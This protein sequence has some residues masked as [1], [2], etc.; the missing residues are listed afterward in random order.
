M[1]K[2]YRPAGRVAAS[3]LILVLALIAVPSLP[4]TDRPATAGMT[5]SSLPAAA[6]DTSVT[7]VGAASSVFDASAWEHVTLGSVDP[8][9]F[10]R[11][12]HAAAV[13]VDRGDAVDP[14][15]LTIIDFSRPSTEAR[16]WVYDLH[17][18]KLL[19]EE[20]V[21]HGR[22]SGKAMATAFS[23]RESSNQSSLGL[24][25]TAET[26]SGKHGYSL[27]LDGLEA[28]FNDKAR[29]RAI[30]MHAADYVNPVAA[31]ANGY[32]GRS[33]GC[34]AIRP[35]ISRRLIDTIKQ[36][37]LLF[38]YYPDDRWLTGSKYL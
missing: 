27:R 1:N 28:G 16:L 36:G 37:G 22:G 8:Q 33:L 31:K 26:Y 7:G 38:A 2:K 6:V 25:R 5:S 35:Q 23:N 29:D 24:F 17:G 30:V 15:T 34:P 9:V 21:S 19:F 13:A 32:L 4:F 18:R 12:L 10:A 11:A 14:G 20:V 3:R